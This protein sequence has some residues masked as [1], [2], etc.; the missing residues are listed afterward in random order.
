M[1]PV[2]T[3]FLGVA[4]RWPDVGLSGTLIYRPIEQRTVGR[5]AQLRPEQTLLGHA[6]AEYVDEL[7]SNARVSRA[8]KKVYQLTALLLSLL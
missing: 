6:A 2:L 8:S 4:L 1:R 3:A 5:R 7:V